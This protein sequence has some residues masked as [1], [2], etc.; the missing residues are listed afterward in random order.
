MPKVSGVTVPKLFPNTMMG[1][2][3]LLHLA[4][5]GGIYQLWRRIWQKYVGRR[6]KLAIFLLEM[7]ESGGKIWEFRE[8][9]LSLQRQK[10]VLIAW[11]S[12]SGGSQDQPQ[13]TVAEGKITK[14]L[15]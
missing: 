15:S 7:S 5:K 6:C 8:F 12:T 3:F 1:T 14:I 11:T 10:E 13:N 4:A 2:L 9:F